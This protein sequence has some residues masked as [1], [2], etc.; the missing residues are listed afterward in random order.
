MLAAVYPMAEDGHYFAAARI[1]PD[2]RLDPGFG[3]VKALPSGK[4]LVSGFLRQQ[5]VL[6]RLTADGRIDRGFGEDG[7]VLLGSHRRMG[8]SHGAPT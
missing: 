4:L 3:E 6:Y 1:L 5:P 8:S 2:G 7:R